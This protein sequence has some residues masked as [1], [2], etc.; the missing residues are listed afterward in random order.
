MK[1]N[2]LLPLGIVGSRAYESQAWS[3]SG[4]VEVERAVWKESETSPARLPSRMARLRQMFGA[5]LTHRPAF[6][7]PGAVL[8]RSRRA[9]G[10]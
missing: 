2:P 4:T 8:S 6:A 3:S 1:K 7:T 9:R 10:G 5:F